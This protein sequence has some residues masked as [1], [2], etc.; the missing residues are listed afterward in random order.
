MSIS[1]KTAGVAQARDNK[2]Q[3]ANQNIPD[4]PE[5]SRS[6]PD[7]D[8]FAAVQKVKNFLLENAGARPPGF[9]ETVH[10][11]GHLYYWS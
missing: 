5:H 9:F 2:K 6:A 11:C 7:P 3:R 1:I 10:L 4:T 8:T